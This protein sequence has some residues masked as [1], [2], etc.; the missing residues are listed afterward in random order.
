L[1]Y[2]TA[3]LRDSVDAVRRIDEM[4]M[5]RGLNVLLGHEG[6][7]NGLLVLA[8]RQK[9]AFSME[10][11]AFLETLG[12]MLGQAIAN[13]QHLVAAE[14]EAARL[15]LLNDLGLLLNNGESLS[16]HFHI[17]AERLGQAVSF[18]GLVLVAASKQP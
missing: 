6:S 9:S 3:D 1:E 17:L 7:P 10:E 4:G 11:R 12:A 18:D 5:R 14:S 16:A 8:R 2:A 15:Q 13:R